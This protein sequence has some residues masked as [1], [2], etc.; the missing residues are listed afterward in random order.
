MSGVGEAMTVATSTKSLFRRGAGKR[1]SGTATF[2]GKA[3]MMSARERQ[4]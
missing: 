4:R 2:L 1:I 3:I